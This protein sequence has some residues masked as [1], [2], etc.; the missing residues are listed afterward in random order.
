MSEANP[1]GN[2][3][4]ADR[5]AQAASAWPFDR[6]RT[7]PARRAATRRLLAGLKAIDSTQETPSARAHASGYVREREPLIPRLNEAGFGMEEIQ[8]DL[9]LSFPSI[10][11]AAQ[12]HAVGQPRDNRHIGTRRGGT[13]P[14][15][16]RVQDADM[17]S[18]TMP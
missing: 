3:G 12:R 17:A 16:A 4:N 11:R 18:R 15:D 7:Q 9:A 8:A 13:A 6:S 10:S 5:P 14:R 1:H 2:A